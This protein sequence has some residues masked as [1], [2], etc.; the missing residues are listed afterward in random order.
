MLDLAQPTAA[1]SGRAHAEAIAIRM[2]VGSAD[3]VAWG[4]LTEAGRLRLTKILPDPDERRSQRCVA[5][6]I[7]QAG[8]VDLKSA[9]TRITNL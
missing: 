6:R 3:S 7:Q 1:S 2:R 4:T 8:T 9:G 5:D